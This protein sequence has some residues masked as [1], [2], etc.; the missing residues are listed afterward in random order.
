MN[1]LNKTLLTLATLIFASY[2]SYAKTEI[3]SST[4]NSL[5]IIYTPELVSN[6]TIS[7][8]GVEYSQPVFIDAGN[9]LEKSGYPQLIATKKPIAVPSPTGF[10]IQN[11]EI[12]PIKSINS[13]I[14]PVYMLGNEENTQ[15]DRRAYMNRPIV[16]WANIQYNGISRDKY[17][18]TLNIIN[19]KYNPFSKS[20]EIPEYVKVTIKFDTKTTNNKPN[21]DKNVFSNSFL[22]SNAAQN[23]TVSD[24]QLFFRN[25]IEKQ[26]KAN[27]IQS[28][29]N[30]SSGSWYKI[31]ISETGVY[32]LSAEYLKDFGIN[33][34]SNDVNTIK[35][36]G[37]GGHELPENVDFA[38]LNQMNQQN[39]IVKKNNDGSLK[40]I[41]FFAGGTSGFEYAK[42]GS[43]KEQLYS[44]FKVIHYINHF[45]K[46]NN[47]LL[48]WGGEDG[49]RSVPTATPS[50][51]IV[52][53]LN[54]FTRRQFF[55]EEL[56]SAFH[57]GSGK[58]FFG[59][60]YFSENFDQNLI[61]LA[62]Q[63][64]VTYRFMLA[65]SGASKSGGYF[66]VLD[67]GK[68]LAD[69]LYLDST[70]DEA[71]RKFFEFSTPVAEVPNKDKVSIKLNYSNAGQTNANGVFDFL[72]L[73]Y[74]SKTIAS[75]GEIY[76]FTDPLLSGLTK[77]NFTGFNGEVYAYDISDMGNPIQL[78]S[79]SQSKFDL[80]TELTENQP[81]RFFISSNMRQPVSIEKVDIIG[82][83]NTKFNNDV[84]V[85]THSK[86]KESAKKFKE[87]REANSDLSVGIFEVTDI[88]NE[89]N[90]GTMDITAIRDFI[91]QA[92]ANW[93]VKPSYVVLWGDGHY[94]Y[95]EILTTQTNF[96]PPH[97][98]EDEFNNFEA[99]KSVCT[100]DY[101]VRVVG[102]DVSPDLAIGRITVNSEQEGNRIVEKIKHYE[103]NSNIDNW[104][105][106]ITLIADDG[107]SGTE[108]TSGDGDLF[109]RHSED[110]SN[111]RV[112]EFMEQRK[113]YI[114]EYESQY[115]AA[116]IRK[117]TANAD[118]L[119]T[120][121]EE[122]ALLLNWY[123][124]GNPQVWSH[125]GILDRDVTIR[126]M[127]NYDKL[128]FLTAATCDF[129]KYDNFASQSG[130]ELMLLN[131]YG[132]S[133]GVFGS[134][135]VVYAQQNH[136]L[137]RALYS[138]LFTRDENGNYPTLGETVFKLKQTFN[139]DNDQKYFL[140]GDPTLRLL[141]P[142]YE[143]VLESIDGIE[144]TDSTSIS[145]KGLQTVNVK[146]YV[147]IP[148]GEYSLA[149]D[150]NG[151]I[152]LK[153]MDGD[154]EIEIT[155]NRNRLYQ[156]RKQGGTLSN[157]N[158][159]VV[160]GR[161]DAEFILPKDISFSENMGKVFSYAYTEDNRFA[162]GSYDR[163]KIDGLSTS[164]ISDNEGPEIK[165]MLDSRKFNA[166]D[167]V[168]NEPL[169]IVDLS[170]NSGINST[171]IGVGHKIEAWIDNNEQSIDLTSEYETSFEDYRKGTAT[172]NLLGLEPGAHFVKLRAWDIYN[173]FSIAE[174]YFN[175][176]EN[177]EVIID[178]VLAYPTPFE[179]NT[180][181]KFQHNLNPPVDVTL[182]IY[183]SKGTKVNTI[184]KKILSAFEGE[185][186]WEGVDAFGTDV[187]IGTYYFRLKL[188]N[189]IAKQTFL[190]GRTVKIK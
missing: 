91:A 14:A 179:N 122:G 173:N 103:T 32:E 34:S 106:K 185:I 70:P 96:V 24:E 168:R 35:I 151:Q 49:K 170:D 30:L 23:W 100:D 83:R 180:K 125:E 102:N 66:S 176:G 52:N 48:T 64:N 93:D 184:N 42:K 58:Q 15:V 29:E 152:K 55:E 47:Y 88:Y 144:I 87:Y 133:I 57:G 157:A 26:T 160:D 145:V 134:S 68:L 112:P 119:K 6:N 53:D 50:G 18:A 86:L 85:I 97:L 110:F 169:L 162:T 107:F 124:H 17:S 128:F 40:S 81:K 27:K 99:V 60:T 33:I 89:Y 126:Q 84:I 188:D 161:F 129:A 65:H 142:H 11:I 164:D 141:I 136:Y 2:F 63:G 139:S 3:I 153:V 190:E 138:N 76:M 20:I 94:D 183:D 166:G 78:E 56:I 44:G 182:D 174:T 90:A 73:H 1:L 163:L 22:N 8:G 13:T 62:D 38:A 175:I 187:S 167:L 177:G 178:N 116:G 104:R 25:D 82:L 21:L 155:D 105:N 9:I 165:I 172:K 71:Y 147:A 80:V 41:V 98:S 59:R 146:G 4:A 19:A 37:N 79:N 114:V 39:I 77:Y 101:Y 127:V 132:G 67:N 189:L 140:L 143:V 74:P 72:E 135:R 109:V 16:E 171:G 181:I 113:V 45:S 108:S 5:S 43:N 121:N 118:I 117:P 154:Q 120:V 69:N 159:S 158:F 7:I 111:N 75:N 61:N 156:F 31:R 150:F 54:L 95:R 186:D 10:S 148:D 46:N 137:N 12:G 149:S 51:D 123:G 131:E 92:M 28:D 130:A 115:T 36:F